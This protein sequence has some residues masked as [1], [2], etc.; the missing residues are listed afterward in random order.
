MLF[1]FLLIEYMYTI[2]IYRKKRFRLLLLHL[3][4]SSKLFFQS[5]STINLLHFRTFASCNFFNQEINIDTII[6][7]CIPSMI[8]DNTVFQA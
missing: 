3:S 1:A 6:F 4:Y 7:P 2:A 8:W 5:S